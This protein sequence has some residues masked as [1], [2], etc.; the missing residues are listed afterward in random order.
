M[1][2][3]G[4]LWLYLVLSVWRFD[5]LIECMISESAVQQLWEMSINPTLGQVMYMCYHCSFL[6]C[7]HYH[8]STLLGDFLNITVRCSNAYLLHFL[9]N[10]LI[11]NQS[12]MSIIYIYIVRHSDLWHHRR[13]KKWQLPL[14][15]C[16]WNHTISWSIWQ[17]PVWG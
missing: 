13:K 8:L 16:K 9:I 15:E 3:P 11:L 1:L 12:H 6:V 10:P 2:V 17:V 4:D 7:W 14:R 5:Y